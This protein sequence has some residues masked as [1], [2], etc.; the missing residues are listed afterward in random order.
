MNCIVCSKKKEDFEVWHNKVII[1]ATYDSEF[2]NN[3]H[4][5][6]MTEKSIICHDCILEIK[7]QV[8]E[9]RK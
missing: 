4:V 6:N 9:N 2:Q 8:E 7:N 1:A 5:R 3:E